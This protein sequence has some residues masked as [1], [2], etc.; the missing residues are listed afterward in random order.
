MRLKLRKLRNIP[1]DQEIEV[2]NIICYP[3]YNNTGDTF[4]LTYLEPVDKESEIWLKR[5]QILE[6]LFGE[7]GTN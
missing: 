7:V 4:D 5:S 1:T 6:H 2:P 3:Y